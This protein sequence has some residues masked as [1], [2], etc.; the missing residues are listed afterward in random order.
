MDEN[1][2][3]ENIFSQI[4]VIMKET[5]KT[6]YL[7]VKEYLFSQ[8]V[9]TMMENG[10]RAKCKDMVNSNGMMEVNMRASIDII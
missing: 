9:I 7:V 2:D 8:M 10:L 4:K 6:I 1:R 3:S 5:S